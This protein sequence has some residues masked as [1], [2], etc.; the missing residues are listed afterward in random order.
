MYVHQYKWVCNIA[1]NNVT[2]VNNIHESPHLTI[3]VFKFYKDLSKIS[4]WFW[5]ALLDLVHICLFIFYRRNHLMWS[6][7][8][9]GLSHNGRAKEQLEVP[10]SIATHEAERHWLRMVWYFGTSRA[11]PSDTSSKSTPPNPF[12]VVQPSRD[13]VFKK[14]MVVTILLQT[15]TFYSFIL[16][17]L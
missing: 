9:R 4:W 3:S 15:T 16:N 8:S 2:V 14:S 1:L 13:W 17:D 6:M 12:L 5:E 7:D 11:A 10:I